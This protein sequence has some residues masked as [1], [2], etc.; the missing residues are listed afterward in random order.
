MV[1][2]TD[3]S[4]GRGGGHDRPRCAMTVPPK[5]EQPRRRRSVRSTLIRNHITRVRPSDPPTTLV[6]TLPEAWPRISACA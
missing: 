6:S 1:Q 4:L 3:L 2:C 5:T